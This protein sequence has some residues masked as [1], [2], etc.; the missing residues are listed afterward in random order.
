MRKAND[1]L[2]Y[3]E[4]LVRESNKSEDEVLA[5]AFRAGLRQLWRER[6]LARYIRGEITRVEAVGVV[7]IDWVEM[8]ERQKEAALEDLTWAMEEERP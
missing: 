7:G 5:L 3:L 8:A 6:V 4:T 2:A 1:T